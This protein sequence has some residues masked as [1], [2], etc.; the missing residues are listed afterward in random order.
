MLEVPPETPEL[1]KSHTDGCCVRVEYWKSLQIICTTL[2]CKCNVPGT[3]ST[4]AS[5]VVWPQY[6]GAGLTA[7]V[8]QLGLILRQTTVPVRGM[9][10]DIRCTVRP[11]WKKLT[12]WANL[13]I[14]TYCFTITNF[15]DNCQGFAMQQSLSQSNKPF[16]FYSHRRRALFQDF[17]YYFT[18]TK[19]QSNFNYPRIAIIA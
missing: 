7:H 5:A 12:V 4:P 3:C 19:R 10:E 8:F 15:E 2:S 18:S 13:T 16:S 17:I 6:Q 9:R 1:V 11:G 14:M